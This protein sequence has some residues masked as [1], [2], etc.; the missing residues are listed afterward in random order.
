MLS[1]K[2]PTRRVTPLSKD[3]VIIISFLRLCACIKSR[4]W[5]LNCHRTNPIFWEY[6]CHVVNKLTNHILEGFPSGYNQ[7]CSTTIFARNN[8][9]CRM[10]SVRILWE[11]RI[12]HNTCLAENVARIQLRIAKRQLY[13]WND[14]LM[15]FNHHTPPWN[16][17]NSGSQLSKN[18]N[19]DSVK[20]TNFW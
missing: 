16:Y 19:H 9:R 1:V 7:S 3:L 2:A 6:R 8:Q 14:F 13:Y 20:A 5:T 15:R 17:N 10:M 12:L 11:Y 18:Y 4:I